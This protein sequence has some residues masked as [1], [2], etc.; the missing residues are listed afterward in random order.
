[1]SD[2][3]FECSNDNGADLAPG[4]RRRRADQAA[5]E[6]RNLTNGSAY[7]CRAFAANTAGISDASSLSDVVRPCASL[8]D[9]NPVVAPALGILMAVLLAGILAAIVALYR[10]RTR[11]YVVAVV[12]VVHTANLGYGSR[13]GMRFERT[14]AQGAVTGV[15]SDRSRKADVRIR[16]RGGD[17]FEVRDRVARYVTTSGQPVVVVDLLG[18]RHHLILRRFRGATAS[19]VDAR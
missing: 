5:A 14:D 12:D 9:C 8:L 2:Y 4:S 15:A 10:D 7:V 18:T 19:A 6:I 1:M 16:H 17:Q 11:G 3:R 13:L